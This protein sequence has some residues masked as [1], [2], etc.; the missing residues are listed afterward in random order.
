MGTIT[1]T[2]NATPLQ[3][4]STTLFDRQQTT[5]YL[6]A[7]VKASTANTYELWRSTNG[8]TSWAV[9]GTLTRANVQEI[10]SIYLDNVGYIH[11]CYRTNESSQDRIYYRRFNLSN[12]TWSAELLTGAPGNGGV[13]G[14]VHTGL[15][16]YAVAS[17][18]STYVAIAAATQSGSSHG[19]TMYG[20]LVNSAGTATYTNSVVAGTRQWLHSG[21][22]RI[23]PSV[24]AEHNGEGKI[25]AGVTP[26][27]WVCWGRTQV[28]TVKLAWSQGWTGP[29]VAS[30]AN[31][32]T[33]TPAQ[34]SVTARWNGS[35]FVAAIPDPS[36]TDR[37]QVL[38]RTI[39]NTGSS[40]LQ[41]PAH[42]AGVVKN[43]GLS[44]NAV[45][46][47]LR[48]YA[49]GTSNNDLYFVDRDADTGVWTSWTSV[50]TTDIMGTPPNQYSIRRG[51]SGNA[52]HDV[53]TAHA[54]APNTLVHTAQS[55]SYA[56]NSP[57]W[58][59]AAIG[60]NS[61]EAAD[62]DRSLRLAWV[63][64]DPDPADTQSAYA[65][66]RQIGA[67]ALA[68]YRASDG[69][70]Q[71]TEQKNVSAS[72]TVTLPIGWGSGSDAATA[73]SAK[74]WDSAD[75]ASAY[76]TAF[77]VVPSV[78]VNPTL[79]S[80]TDGG[81]V[82]EASVTAQW[83]A[84]EQVGYRVGMVPLSANLVLNPYLE[85]NAN[86]WSGSGGTVA[87]STAQFHSGAASL[88]LTP[89]GVTATVQARSNAGT[90][91]EG[92][93]YIVRGWVRC[94]VARDITVRFRFLDGGGSAIA[95]SGS[96]ASG[97][98]MAVAANTWT[99]FTHN[100][101]SPNGTATVQW[102]VELTGTPAGSHLTYVDEAWLF[103]QG[104]IAHD[105][106]WITD[107]DRSYTVPASLADGTTWR[108]QIETRNNEGLY[109]DADAADFTVDFVE[110]ATPT[111]TLAPDPGEGWVYVQITNPTPGGG[112]PV[113]ADQD[114]YRR[115]IGSTDDG[116][117]IAAGLASGA[118]HADWQAVS[119]VAYE[120]RTD[121][122]GTNGTQVYSAWTR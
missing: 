66:S 65:L 64:S 23:T 24:D 114:L 72:S 111:L 96:T 71:A 5:G 93:R 34:D 106:G 77:V 46:G 91:A 63:F 36:T 20:V 33:L 28:Y 67:G 44:Y 70:W 92:V 117:R 4:P 112:Q 38:I 113:V 73:F 32:V 100:T 21:T 84:S 56:P 22:G 42:P 17:G 97:K 8:G 86:N 35:R 79:D 25:G 45:T 15:D 116:V 12:A 95:D 30:K 3:Y 9:Y 121:T 85:T 76:G 89:D 59:T 110:P 13:A 41:S 88:L 122:R 2:T 14:A 69:T 99:Y 53:Y 98:T 60:I 102:A 105:T 94:A 26:N 55:L 29:T 57:T 51:S 58:D 118:V 74:V 61:G 7:M 37:V 107:T 31:P 78:K 62:V 40:V 90:A 75:V 108:I 109:S 104:L 115:I 50:T 47:D 68:Y 48:V 87:R 43:C 10:G 103:A 52:K 6:F 19:V 11:W 83:T 119:D 1:T 54:G 18:S 16:L 39:A 49:V 120:Y 101:V 81:T 27:L 82:T 80:P